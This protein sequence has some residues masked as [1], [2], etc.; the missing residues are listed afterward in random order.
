MSLDYL[1]QITVPT[2]TECYILSHHHSFFLVHRQGLGFRNRNRS[3]LHETQYL[4]LATSS[5]WEKDENGRA[6]TYFT[7]GRLVR[8]SV[9]PHLSPALELVVCWLC[10]YSLIPCISITFCYWR[11]GNGLGV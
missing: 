6:E 7:V 8:L 4:G 11:D 2:A 3:T 9:G 1:T 5:I 10:C